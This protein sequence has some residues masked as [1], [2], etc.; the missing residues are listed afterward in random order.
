MP[1]YNISVSLLMYVCVFGGCQQTIPSRELWSAPR[2]SLLFTD[3][4]KS[5]PQERVLSD[6]TGQ[7]SLNFIPTD[8]AARRRGK[9]TPV[10][11]VTAPSPG[12]GDLC[13]CA[14]AYQTSSDVS[15]LMHQQTHQRPTDTRVWWCVCVCW[16]GG[17]TT[18]RV[19]LATVCQSAP[20]FQGRYF[21][22][23]P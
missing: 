4:A 19:W 17:W 20:H 21:K 18:E 10:E 13:V 15:L 2:H 3:A 16:G 22:G 14:R 11:R 6:K 23:L 5:L 1:L 12:F 9:I 8:T 7:L